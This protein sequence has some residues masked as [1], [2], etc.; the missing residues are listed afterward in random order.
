MFLTGFSSSGAFKVGQTTST[1]NPA[2]LTAMYAAPEALAE[3][4]D[5][6]PRYGR[7]FDVFG[8]GCVFCDMLTVEGGGAV[9]GFT[10]FLL[11]YGAPTAMAFRGGLRYSEYI[12]RI[13]EWFGKFG[14][15]LSRLFGQHASRGSQVETFRGGR[16][17][18][19]SPSEEMTWL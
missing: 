16:V 6:Y 12:P 9:S 17:E 2:R 4:T 14:E 10:D 5:S 8:L 19:L 13:H 18:I 1:A 7:S 3:P 11:L 15:I